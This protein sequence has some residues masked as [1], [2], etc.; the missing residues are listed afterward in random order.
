LISLLPAAFQNLRAVVFKGPR[1]L[2]WPQCEQKLASTGNVTAGNSLAT[3]LESDRMKMNN[4][5]EV[6][7]FA[8]IVAVRMLCSMACGD[9]KYLTFTVSVTLDMV[10]AQYLI[11]AA[12]CTSARS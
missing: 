6:P 8:K 9:P 11:A 5:D 1:S 10:A 4:N 12:K 2:Q 7:M 3:I